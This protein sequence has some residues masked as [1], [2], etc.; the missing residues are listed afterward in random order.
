MPDKAVFVS[1][2]LLC[3]QRYR[4]NSYFNAPKSAPNGKKLIYILIQTNVK[5]QQQYANVSCWRQ[6]ETAWDS[7]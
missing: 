7:F 1:P 4:G 6:Q 5:D 3:V 2:V